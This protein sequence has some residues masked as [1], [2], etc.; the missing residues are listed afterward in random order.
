MIAV[1]MEVVLNTQPSN[2]INPTQDMVLNNIKQGQEVLMARLK[3]SEGPQY[4]IVEQGKI[5][6]SLPQEYYS[7]MDR[8]SAILR[9][10]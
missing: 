4:D 7:S 8:Q 6:S 9:Y 3:S 1:K 10:R 2:P 5:D